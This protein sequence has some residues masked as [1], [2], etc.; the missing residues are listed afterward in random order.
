MELFATRISLDE[1]TI[2]KIV[3]WLNVQLATSAQAQAVLKFAHWNVKGE[4]FLPNHK[5]I[6]EI[7]DYMVDVTDK[8]AER[9]TALGGVAEGLPAQ[10]AE[11]SQLPPYEASAS[12]DG[13][14][15]I[16][17]VADTVA[18][19]ANHLREGIDLTGEWKDLVTQNILCDLVTQLDK[20]LYF[21][22]AHLR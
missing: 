6:D 1:S 9:I 22:E 15:H 18:E 7:F 5:L 13:T 12:D 21:L 11:H 19:V 16:S 3:E 4:G 14:A 17:A 2:T 20:Y 10:I 8:L